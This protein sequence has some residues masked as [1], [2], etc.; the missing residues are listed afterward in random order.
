MALMLC[1]SYFCSVFRQINRFGTLHSSLKQCKHVLDFSWNPS[2]DLHGWKLSSRTWSSI[3]S[4]QMK[5]STWIVHS[6]D[7]CLYVRHYAL[8]VVR[9]TK[10][11]EVIVMLTDDSV[12]CVTV[13]DI[14]SGRITLWWGKGD[15]P[16]AAEDRTWWAAGHLSATSGL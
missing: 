14:V 5:Q 1:I 8:L 10:E 2:W 15:N 6:R 3:T 9:A 4:P 13:C 16:E 11:E 12:L 7:W